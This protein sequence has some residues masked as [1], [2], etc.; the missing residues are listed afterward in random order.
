[1][2]DKLQKTY[3]SN[4]NLVGE[5]NDS[6][7]PAVCPAYHTIS[8]AE[9]EIAV[10][11]DGDFVSARALKKLDRAT[12]AQCTEKSENRTSVPCPMGLTDRL[13]YLAGDHPEAEKFH[14][15]Y[16]DALDEWCNS[17]FGVP[18]VQAVAAY[19]RKGCLIA[20]LVHAGLLHR[21]ESGK[22]AEKWD[23]EW[24]PK[25][26]LYALAYSPMKTAARFCVVDKN[27]E[28]INL[29]RAKNVQESWIAYQNS[30]VDDIGLCY[31]TGEIGQLSRFSP[32]KIR[33]PSDRAKLI[34]RSGEDIGRMPIADAMQIGKEAN[35]QAHAMLRYL[36]S[37]YGSD[38]N[39]QIVLAWNVSGKQL[40]PRLITSSTKQICDICDISQL[41]E[42]KGLYD[43]NRESAVI[44]LN[45]PTKGRLSITYYREMT[46]GALLDR[47]VDWHR[48][49]SRG[50]SCNAPGID[51][52]AKMDSAAG[53]QRTTDILVG[54]LVDGLPIPAAFSRRFAG[55]AESKIQQGKGDWET[56]VACAVLRGTE[57][58]VDPSGRDYIFGRCLGVCKAAEKHIHP[59]C[60]AD[61]LQ[62]YRQSPARTLSQLCQQLSQQLPARWDKKIESALD[63]IGVDDYNNTPIS[64]AYL[65]G[66]KDAIDGIG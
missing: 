34:S 48:K 54:C 58:K 62:Q 24:G 17:P 11:M 7:A 31:A 55:L 37:E 35:D 40:P 23:K 28:A 52:I 49:L 21:M 27:G 6:G 38:N 59:M 2:I 47:V 18:E 4:L 25:P 56:Y 20:D 22:I 46:T 12:F 9:I 45:A 65:I 33:Y 5:T 15:P 29:S 66:Y 26:G 53:S 63:G 13:K 57:E 64:P 44:V 3:L 1:M 39:G 32:N 43:P 42:I 8:E 36:V 41:D 10:S 61:N 16:M 60:L 51:A 19:L 50:P 14:G 30:K